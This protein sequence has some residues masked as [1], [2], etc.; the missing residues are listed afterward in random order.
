MSMYSGGLVSNS[1]GIDG[2]FLE[3]IG[4]LR[5]IASI[6]RPTRRSWQIAAAVAAAVVG[7]QSVPALRVAGDRT[8]TGPQRLALELPWFGCVDRTPPLRGADRKKWIERKRW[9]GR[10]PERRGASLR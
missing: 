4:T 2:I 3:W 10:V 9:L 7:G 5:L 1:V 8:T 6:R